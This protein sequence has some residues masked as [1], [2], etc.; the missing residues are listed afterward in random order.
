VTVRTQ[1][2]AVK[3]RQQAPSARVLT[4]AQLAAVDLVV[5]G[6]ADAEVAEA[7]GVTRQT[8]WG[9]R[10]Y[11]PEFR[12]AL[13]TRRR[14]VFGQASDR[15]RALLSR[16][17]DVL[18]AELDAQP[19]DEWKVK[20]ALKVLD[21]GAPL[22]TA[23]VLPAGPEDPDELLEAEAGHRNRDD[24]SRLLN[25]GGPGPAAELRQEWAEKLAALEAA[26]EVGK[27]EA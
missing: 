14:E 1:T 26:S 12:A 6:K 4:A 9:W 2:K 22:L 24:L 23:Q 11:H 8:V 20:V 5:T 19:W 15:L 21:Y 27:V 16:S 13:N 18:A 10:H 25:G 7:V 3:S 17:I